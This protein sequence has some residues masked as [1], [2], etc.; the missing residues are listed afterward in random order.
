MPSVSV[1]TF[2]GLP[3][4]YFFLCMT[5]RL[6]LVVIFTPILQSGNSVWALMG[7][8][9]LKAFSF[10]HGVPRLNSLSF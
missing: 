10:L 5:E 1:N 3:K 2:P 7:I 9:S 6:R 4:G 8:F